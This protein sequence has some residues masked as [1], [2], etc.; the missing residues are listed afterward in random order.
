MLYLLHRS[1]VLTDDAEQDLRRHRKTAAA[2]ALYWHFMDL[3]WIVLF[4]LLYVWSG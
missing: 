4:T 1:R 2:V 3:L